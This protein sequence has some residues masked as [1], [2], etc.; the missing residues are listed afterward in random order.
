MA[1]R[2]WYSIAS[3][4]RWKRAK[5]VCLCTLKRGHK[6]SQV[7]LVPNILTRKQVPKAS[8]NGCKEHGIKRV[9]KVQD[10]N[11]SVPK[12][13]FVMWRLR[14]SMCMNK[15]FYNF[16]NRVAEV[17]NLPKFAMEAYE[18][19]PNTLSIWKCPITHG[20]TY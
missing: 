9:R 14:T 12:G 5:K 19:V 11:T 2:I 1:E 8:G 16:R 20:S 4:N 13:S 10:R 6:E 7:K 18:T 15:V 17:Q 3:G